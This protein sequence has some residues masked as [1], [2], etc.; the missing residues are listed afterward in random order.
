MELEADAVLPAV[1]VAPVVVLARL[2]ETLAVVVVVVFV[3]VV[4]PAVGAIKLT[5][6]AP[7][8]HGKL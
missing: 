1:G 2:E 6:T 4:V 8:D 5:L 7:P 3:V